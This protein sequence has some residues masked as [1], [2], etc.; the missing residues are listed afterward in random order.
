MFRG[1]WEAS[2][3]RIERASLKGTGRRAVVRVGEA[4]GAWPNGITLDHRARTLYWVDARSDAIQCATYWGADIRTVLR[5]HAAL[6]H[7]FAVTLLDARGTGRTGA[8]TPS[9]APTS[10]AALTSPCCSGRSRSPST[11]R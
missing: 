2:A 5:A 3:A 6:A 9:C 8:P 11:S 10:S 4:G 1:Y 7:P